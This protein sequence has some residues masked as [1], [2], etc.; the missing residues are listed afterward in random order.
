M[1]NFKTFF[2]NTGTIT[3]ILPG[4]FKPPTVGHFLALQ[5]ML[6]EADRAIVYIGGKERDGITQDMS[7][8]IWC[9]Y[10]PYL[11]KEVTI[12]KSPVSPVKSTYDYI[13]SHLKEKIIVG[14]GLKDE[15]DRFKYLSKD[16]QKYGNVVVRHIEMKGGGISGTQT[17][18][19]IQSKDKR[20]VDFFVPPQVKETDKDIIKRI[21][22]IA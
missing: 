21:L 6:D 5:S 14:V 8:Q 4:G 7:Y 1:R 18:E 11:S 22:N 3:A 9:I 19:M 10:A 16:T 2:E 20:A 13:D 17:R 12:E 15:I